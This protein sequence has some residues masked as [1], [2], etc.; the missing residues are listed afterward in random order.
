MSMRV[1]FWS[2]SEF[3][4]QSLSLLTKIGEILGWKLG[5]VHLEEF[6][7]NFMWGGIIT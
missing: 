3:F 5:L 4:L 7:Q 2:I 1:S 6:N